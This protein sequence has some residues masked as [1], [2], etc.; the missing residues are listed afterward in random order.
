MRDNVLRAGIRREISALEKVRF[1][2]TGTERIILN[3]MISSY[4]RILKDIQ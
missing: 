1:G 2:S 4:K 3:Q